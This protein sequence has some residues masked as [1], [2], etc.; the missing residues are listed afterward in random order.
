MMKRMMGVAG[1]IGVMINAVAAEKPQTPFFYEF[2]ELAPDVWVG[3]RPDGPRFPVQGST[4]IVIEDDGVLVFDSGGVAA[5][6]DII[7]DKVRSLTEAPITHVV[8]S[9]WHGDHHFGA[10]RFAEEFPDV[11]IIAHRFTDAAIKGDRVDYI[12][13]YPTIADR[14]SPYAKALETGVD[15]DESPLS[16]INRRIYEQMMRDAPIVAEE[17]KRVAVTEPTVVFDEKYELRLGERRIEL[18]Y[19]GHGNTDGDIV[20]WLPD[21]KIVA[22]GDLVVAPTP[23]AFNVPPRGW[24]KTLKKLNALGYHI[25]VPGHGDVQRDTSYVDLIIE[26]S[27]AIAD[28]RDAMIADGVEPQDIPDRL[29]FSPFKDRFTNG[30]AYTEVYYDSYFEGPLRAAAVKELSGEPMVVI[31]PSKRAE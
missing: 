25:L 9:H 17:Y 6:A 31:G 24:A 15:T 21:E 18:L 12:Q 19:L 28:Q 27:E 26:T 20:M 2:D 23:Y 5:M 8:I 13:T 16:D 29:D 4:V 10:Y 30:D 22:T 7:I 3:V 11:Q 14:L 1:L